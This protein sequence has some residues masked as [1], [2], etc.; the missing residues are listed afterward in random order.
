M[1]RRRIGA[2]ERAEIFLAHGG[3]CHLCGLKIREGEEWDVS[4]AIP[5]AA[6]GA[7]DRSN[8]APAH[9]ARCHRKQTSEI[10]IPLIAKVKRVR[11]RA[12]G[13]KLPSRNP[14]PGGRRSKWKRKMDGTVV[15]R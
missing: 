1:A 11:H 8:M 9:R 13:A 14:I 10:D 4:H 5:L 3:M 15:R 6:G 12:M 2:K 7:D